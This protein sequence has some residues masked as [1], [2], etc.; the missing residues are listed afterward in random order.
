MVS[1]LTGGSF[2]TSADSCAKNGSVDGHNKTAETRN[3][4]RDDRKVVCARKPN[5]LSNKYLPF[6]CVIANDRERIFCT[7]EFLRVFDFWRGARNRAES[8]WEL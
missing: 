7:R 3:C 2:N 1:V 6:A 8:P 5:V 4:E